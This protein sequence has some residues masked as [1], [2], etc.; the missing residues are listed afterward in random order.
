MSSDRHLFTNGNI[1]TSAG[2]Q[3]CADAMA[4][5]NGRILWIGKQPEM[6]ESLSFSQEL[7]PEWT[8]LPAD[9]DFPSIDPEAVLRESQIPVLHRVDGSIE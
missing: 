9:C 7:V 8:L 1:F 4:V 3:P 5:E 2:D 6:P